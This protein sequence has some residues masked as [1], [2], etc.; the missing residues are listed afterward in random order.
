MKYKSET[1]NLFLAEVK[2]EMKINKI[3]VSNLSKQLGIGR[4]SLYIFLSGK[5]NPKLQTMENIAAAL[6]M[7]VV[8]CLMEKED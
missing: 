6:K 1:F 5:H 7:K 3:S 2:E 8:V 4:T